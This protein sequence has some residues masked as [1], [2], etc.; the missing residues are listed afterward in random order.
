MLSQGEPRD[1]AVNFDRPTI[2]LVAVIRNT[3]LKNIK[4]E[5]SVGYFVPFTGVEILIFFFFERITDCH[6]IAQRPTLGSARA[7]TLNLS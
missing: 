5:Y 7:E 3:L 2:R 1:A 6:Q 4:S